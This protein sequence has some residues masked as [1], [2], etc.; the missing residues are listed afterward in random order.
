MNKLEKASLSSVEARTYISLLEHGVVKASEL[1]SYTGIP[2]SNLYAILNSLH[3]KGLASY[4]FQNNVKIY[5]ASN[6]DTLK[7]LFDSEVEKIRQ[8]EADILQ[9]ISELK[10]RKPVEQK[11]FGF[12]Y[13]ES[14]HGL[15]A[16]W[17]EIIEQMGA[18]QTHKLHVGSPKAYHNLQGFYN[19]YHNK[20]K[21]LKIPT[22]MIFDPR[23]KAL[24]QKR[25]SENLE[26]KFQTTTSKC[27]WGIVDDKLF[28][29]YK[30]KAFLIEDETFVESFSEMFDKLWKAI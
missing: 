21:S 8:S 26:I 12:R 13:F 11:S 1:S 2:T 18:N 6:P 19:L 15:R 24:A 30:E 27:E 22:K 23:D 9:T 5:S 28:M 10:R 7:I 3:E 17:L 25:Q 4:S 14:D 16:M 29:Q 20:R